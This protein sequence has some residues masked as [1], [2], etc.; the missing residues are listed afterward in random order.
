M[1]TGT[2]G[3]PRDAVGGA[4]RDAR[5]AALRQYLRGHRPPERHGTNL[6]VHSDHSFSVFASAT[7]AVA[8]AVAAGVEV[9]GLNDFFTTAGGAEFQAA[10]QVA[11]L[12]GVLSLECIAMDRAAQAAGTLLN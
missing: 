7:A 2:D 5:L 10:C 1:S 11:Q 4:T 9:L 8:E 3:T 12:P 6:H